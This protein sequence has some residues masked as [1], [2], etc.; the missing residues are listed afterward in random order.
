MGLYYQIYLDA[1]DSTELD[2]CADAVGAD[3][4][5]SDDETKEN[6]NTKVR[7]LVLLKVGA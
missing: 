2:A 4:T 7:Q 3:K 1:M 6:I 5:G